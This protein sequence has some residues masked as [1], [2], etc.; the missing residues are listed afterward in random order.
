MLHTLP[1]HW[2]IL[3][4]AF[5]AL[6]I[7]ARPSS[8]GIFVG[9]TGFDTLAPSINTSSLTTATVF[10]LGIL[11]DN[12]VSTG[13]LSSIPTL[14]SFGPASF[15]LGS[16]TALTFG[17]PAYGT[18]AET[19]APALLSSSIAGGNVVGETFYI[20]GTFTPSAALGGGGPQTASFTVNFNQ[21]G[22]PTSAIAAS[23]TL[24]V[25]PQSIPEPNSL[26]M[27][28]VGFGTLVGVASR[29]RGFV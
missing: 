10:D 15:T 3:V 22:G 2:P 28:I 26:A 1:R 16:A 18:F 7:V 20:L 19:D 9:T 12:G 14:A 11:V 23:A 27:A 13:T 8:A 25:P 17:N 24:S 21:S 5:V 4:L 6:T 29:R